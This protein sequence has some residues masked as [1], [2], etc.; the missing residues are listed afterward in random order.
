[1][2]GRGER[3]KNG[4]ERIKRD[5]NSGVVIELF[6]RGKHAFLVPTHPLKNYSTSL[7]NRTSII[8]IIQ[9]VNNNWAIDA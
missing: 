4:T 1:V 7:F 3:G 8:I 6:T 5:S 2:F 9:Q